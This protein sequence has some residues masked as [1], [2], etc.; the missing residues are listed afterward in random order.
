MLSENKNIYNIVKKC[1][2]FTIRDF[3]IKS[4]EK[5]ANEEKEKQQQQQ[6]TKVFNENRNAIKEIQKEEEEVGETLK[7]TDRIIN[8][9]NNESC[10]YDRAIILPPHLLK[11]KIR[12]KTEYLKWRISVLERDNFRC[13]VCS[14][15]IKDNKNLWLE[16]H[17]AKS[18]NDIC[19]EN[20]ITTIEQ[21][22]SCKE[23]WRLDNGISLCFSCHKD[24]E[25]IRIKIRNIFFV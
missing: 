9:N 6:L 12:N 21:A 25:R 20:N 4:F 17:H 23:I 19:N 8:S 3:V 15:S 2:Y 7:N 10:D 1:D 13:R 16:V 5:I 22:L 11:L 18:F 14:A 24:I